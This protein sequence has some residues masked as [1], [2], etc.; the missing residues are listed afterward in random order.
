MLAGAGVRAAQVVVDANVDDEPR[1]G[2][3]FGLVFGVLTQWDGQWYMEIVRRGYP[4]SIPPDITYFQLEARGRV[5]PA[6]PDDRPA[7]LDRMLPGGDTFA[8]LF[9]QRRCCRWPPS[10]SSAC[11]PGG[12]TA[13]T[14]PSGRW[15]CSP[16][17]PARSC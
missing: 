10:C 15:C 8:A 14:S 13:P 4:R 6:V 11:S 9:A 2:T 1:P 17:S 3:P 5:L 12:C 16:C 7:V